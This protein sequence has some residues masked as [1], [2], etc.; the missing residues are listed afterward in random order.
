MVFDESLECQEVFSVT[1]GYFD[2][3]LEVFIEVLYF[4][5][6]LTIRVNLK[7]PW[8][9]FV[10]VVVEFGVFEFWQN[11]LVFLK[12]LRRHLSNLVVQFT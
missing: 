1:L 7:L 10:E 3:F 12:L 9:N 11:R 2:N 8:H 5:L 4:A 6:S